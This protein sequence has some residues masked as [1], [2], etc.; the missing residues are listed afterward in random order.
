MEDSK[1]V[2]QDLEEGAGA[3]PRDSL[4]RGPVPTIPFSNY[5]PPSG[6]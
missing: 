2:D 4:P 3:S 1:Q 6:N 5:D